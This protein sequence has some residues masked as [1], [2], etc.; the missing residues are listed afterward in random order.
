[1]RV[2]LLS[3]VLHPFHVVL[4]DEL[5]EAVVRF[6]LLHA[7]HLGH[8]TVGTAQFQFPAHEFFVDLCP[9]VP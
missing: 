6:L 4:L 5:R 9:V 8:T 2:V 1:M 7:K 3:S